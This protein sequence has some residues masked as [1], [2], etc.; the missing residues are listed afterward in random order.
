[1]IRPSP[2]ALS[3]AGV[4]IGALMTLSA[5][6]ISLAPPGDPGLV[7][8]LNDVNAEALALF[9]A[10]SGGASEASFAGLSDDYDQVIGG[11]DALRLRAEARDVPRL[12]GA[13]AERI[14]DWPGLAAACG[15][16]PTACVN[17]SPAS[18]GEAATTLRTMK[19]DHADGG[20]EADRPPIYRGAYE[21]SIKQALT[22]ET[23][24]ADPARGGS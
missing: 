17:A 14:E 5:C 12:A 2:P 23:A 1:M 10:V 18:I 11:L 19:A 4:L 20:L 8:G 15:G 22:I 3:A 7:E 9:S 24:L 21:A 13:V 16:D 6:T